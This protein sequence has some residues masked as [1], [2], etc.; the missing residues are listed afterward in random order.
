MRDGSSD[1]DPTKMRKAITTNQLMRSSAPC[2]DLNAGA[3]LQA[4]C[5][6]DGVKADR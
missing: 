6:R 2:G 4:T 3:G 5:R 1:D